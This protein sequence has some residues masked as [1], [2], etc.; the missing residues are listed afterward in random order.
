MKHTRARV[1]SVFIK[2]V[3]VEAEEKEAR[4]CEERE[5]VCVYVDRIV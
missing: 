3:A 2:E 1:T 4:Q 5:T